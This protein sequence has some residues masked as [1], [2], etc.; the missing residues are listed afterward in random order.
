MSDNITTQIS[1]RRSGR[2]RPEISYKERDDK[3][4]Y[5]ELRRAQGYTVKRQRKDLP[6]KVHRNGIKN[7]D[8][9]A[10]AICTDEA[11]DLLDDVLNFPHDELE[12]YEGW[13]H[14]NYILHTLGV[15]NVRT[16]EI[17]SM[18]ETEIAALRKPIYGFIFLFE[19]DG[20]PISDEIV[21]PPSNMWF[22]AQ[23]A[24][25]SCATVALL[26]VLMNCD[27]VAMGEKVRK[28]KEETANMVL[29]HRGA[30]LSQDK[31]LRS[32]HNTFARR[33]DLMDADLGMMN[34]W[35][36]RNKRQ[37]KGKSNKRKRK[38]LDPDSAKHYVGYIPHDGQLWELDGLDGGVICLGPYEGDWACAVI[39]HI[40]RKVEELGLQANLLALSHN[41]LASVRQK[42]AA[43]M[44]CY[45][46]LQQNLAASPTLKSIAE[47]DSSYITCKQENTEQLGKMGLTYEEVAATAAPD[48]FLK[49]LAGPE[50]TQEY[51]DTT[52]RRLR[53]EQRDLRLEYDAARESGNED[54]AAARR[55]CQDYTPLVHGW[56]RA[57]G[58][59][60]VL[61]ALA[62]SQ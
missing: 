40:Q 17:F 24:S 11:P 55:R 31:F 9:E 7:A 43:N 53:A 19:C 45:E 29:S 6:G 27:E 38:A 21:P 32:T 42:L 35:E 5:D 59:A 41:P 46:A 56:L 10:D 28:F 37:N 36:E 50:M 8:E 1:S 26:N 30:Y 49:E 58:E 13:A 60:G 25:N 47:Q 57:M 14:F 23:T 18:D 33:L 44:A 15:S 12:A 61:E 2:V 52:M 20:V 3:D 51:A 48:E 62:D 4:S 34:Q 16:E 22:A 39:P 54:L